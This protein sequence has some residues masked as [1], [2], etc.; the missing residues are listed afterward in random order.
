MTM[1]LISKWIPRNC[2][3]CDELIFDIVCQEILKYNQISSQQN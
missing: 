2:L 1:K 3:K